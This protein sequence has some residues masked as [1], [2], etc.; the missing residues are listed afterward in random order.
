M[1]GIVAMLELGGGRPAS[2]P[3]LDAMA[4][5][6]EHRGPDERG[7]WTEAPAGLAAQRL[8]I[9]DL[10]GGRQP[11]VSKDGSLRLV[12]NG[13]I[14]NA[15]DLRE[16][17]RRRG[18]V[19]ATR[20]DME[21]IL[22]AYED[23]GPACLERLDGMF[24]FVLWDAPA[25]RLFAA[26]DRFGEKPLYY[27]RLADRLL[28]ASELKALPVHPDVSRELDR[29]ALPRH[30][31]HADVPAPHAILRAVRKLLPAHYMMAGP[32]GS[33]TIRRYW[34]PPRRAL[35][36]PTAA[37]AADGV[38]T[39]LRASVARR[40]ACDVP[41][42]CFLSGGVDSGLVPAPERKHPHGRSGAMPPTW[43]ARS[44]RSTTRPSCA[45][46]TRAS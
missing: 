26:R 40:V 37:E 13:E 28:L 2:R 45:A 34:T 1:C 21:V 38:L 29:D 24:A 43:R 4:L 41:W 5:A 39:R 9:V 17:L 11:L 44:A 30:P 22:H 14:Y 6:I 36:A 12:A 15:D 10:A 16:A 8:G 25:R 3:T 32:D 31:T 7:V 20:T 19:F 27:A 18:H 33:Q 35:A 46:A 42:G 23:D